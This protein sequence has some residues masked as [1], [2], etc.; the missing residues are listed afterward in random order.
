[1]VRRRTLGRTGSPLGH[2]SVMVG[3]REKGPKDGLEK[4]SPNSASDASWMMG[5]IMITEK[6]GGNSEKSGSPYSGKWGKGADKVPYPNHLT[7]LRRAV[8]A[9]RGGPRSSHRLI[10]IEKNDKG[11]E[12]IKERKARGR[13]V[14]RPW[15]LGSK[16]GKGRESHRKAGGTG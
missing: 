14:R 8:K 10:E 1:V 9:E 12:F 5:S 7:T 2:I 6:V 11:R 4:K 15:G 13:G 16:R 3:G